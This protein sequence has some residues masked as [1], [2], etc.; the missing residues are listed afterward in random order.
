MDIVEVL[1]S[2]S[3]SGV[4]VAQPPEPTVFVH[5][6][7]V[8]DLPESLPAAGTADCSQVIHSMAREVSF[9]EEPDVRNPQVR[10]REGR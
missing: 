3:P 7:A 8:L 4:E 9:T 10:F 5:M 2:C 1:P 6:G